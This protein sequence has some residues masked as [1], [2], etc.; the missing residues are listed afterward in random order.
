[1]KIAS[2]WSVVEHED[3]LTFTVHIFDFGGTIF[4]KIKENFISIVA[5]REN[6][7]KAARFDHK[8]E[9]GNFGMEM[10]PYYL[11]LIVQ[12]DPSLR[13]SEGAARLYISKLKGC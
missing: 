4:I 7:E 1:M 2:K 5:A 11:S 3:Y 8:D 13:M 6:K 10:N 12:D 9:M